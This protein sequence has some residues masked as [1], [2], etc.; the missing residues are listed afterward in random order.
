MKEV[1]GDLWSYEDRKGF[2]ILI[3]TNGFIKNDGT[4]VMGAGV[5]RQAAERYPDLPR[6]LGESLQRRGN[7]VSRLTQ[8]FYSFPT[9][10]EWMDDSDLKLIRKSTKRLRAIAEA[11]PNIKYILPKPGTGNGRLAWEKVKPIVETLP[12]NVFV[13]DK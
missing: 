7:V 10:H 9:K 6:L 3:P 2:I 8:Q 12:D 1:R 11:N 4:G 5:A 13:I